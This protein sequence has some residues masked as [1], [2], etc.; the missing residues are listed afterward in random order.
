MDRIRQLPDIPSMPRFSVGK[1]NTAELEAAVHVPSTSAGKDS[2]KH[3]SIGNDNDR[4]L[5]A[6]SCSRSFSGA[7]IGA[8]S[9]ELSDE[10]ASGAHVRG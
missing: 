6:A 1:V 10:S 5:S 3:G 8:A 2:G 9:G 7:S 4:R